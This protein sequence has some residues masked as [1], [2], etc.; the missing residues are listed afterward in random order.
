MSSRA[1]RA[2]PANLIA[3]DKP[4]P[5]TEK[6]K[7]KNAKQRRA[8]EERAAAAED[9]RNRLKRTYIVMKNGDV[10]DFGLSRID[11]YWNTWTPPANC[12][13]IAKDVKDLVGRVNMRAL[14]FHMEVTRQ[15]HAG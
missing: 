11:L 14:P 10:L 3:L 15:Q 7:A 9:K 13:T 5:A 8:Q 6:K 2:K 1:T 4:P 12:K